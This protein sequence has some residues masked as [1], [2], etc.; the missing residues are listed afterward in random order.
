MYEPKPL[1]S[2]YKAR[3]FRIPDYQRGYAWG[4][5]QWDAF[6]EDLIT[7]P[8]SRSHYTGVLTL[9][10]I[11]STDVQED[12]KKFW[13]VDDHSYKLYHIVDGQQRLTTF[14]LFLQA[15]IELLRSM[16]ENKDKEDDAIYLAD[17]LSIASVESNFLFKVKPGGDPFRTYKFGYTADNPSYDYMR[18]QILGEEGGGEVSETFYTLNL[19]KGKCYFKER[20]RAWHKEEGISRLRDLYRTLTKRFLVNEYVIKDEFDVCVAFE[21]MNNRGKA[22]SDLELL[23]NRLIYLTTLYTDAELN[24]AERK[25]LRNSVNDA[26]KE[27]YSQLGRNK[28]KPLNDDN[29]LRAH[30]MMYFKFSRQTGRDYIK[31]LLQEQFTPQRVHC[32]IVQSV[33]LEEAEEQTSDADM[34]ADD[35]SGLD[36]VKGSQPMMVAKLR[37]IEIGDYVRSLQMSSVHWFRTYFPEMSNYVTPREVEWIQRLNRLR[38]RYFR[39]LLM[40]IL[41][42]CDDAGQRISVFK[43][44][45]RFVFVV[46]HLTQTRSHYRSSEFSNA[47]RAV[48]RGDMDLA[49]LKNRLRNRMRFTFTSE[50]NFA[51]GDFYLLLQ[52]KFDNDKGYYSWNGLRYFLYEYESEL[53]KGLIPR[54]GWADWL[55]TP[56]NTT[57]IEHIYPQSDR[58]KAWWPTFNNVREEERKAYRNSLGNLL[59]LSSA[60]NSSLQDDAFV[61]KK[62]PRLDG[63]GRKLR[64]GYANGSHSEIEVSQ[65]EDWGPDE[66]RERGIRL[67]RFMEKRWDI[68][69]ANDQVREK[70]LFIGSAAGEEPDREDSE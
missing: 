50:G 21:T 68:R 7:L 15:F 61:D 63:D 26:W 67:I 56:R 18:Y 25:V 55:N 23:K 38:M 14:T 10:E 49:E 13:L 40:A 58:A 6:W 53:S 70:L 11:P 65:Y 17:T 16:P 30:W 19:S 47:V 31:F 3:L 20:L 27:V 2:L 62:R 36:E 43:E 42:N 34:E 37:P 33:E 51:H 32:K 46:F 1:N 35:E 29:F 8:D 44:I 5:E 4:Q 57:S 69:F 39:P 52:K 28:S 12:D 9:N 66:V 48:D 64:N 59:L 41:K 54:V 60:I 45:E 22:L 24:P